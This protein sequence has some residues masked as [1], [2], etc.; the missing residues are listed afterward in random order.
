MT[1]TMTNPCREIVIPAVCNLDPLETLRW[2]KYPVG[3]NG[4]V[5]LVDWMG[6][7]DA[8]VQA[9]RTSYGKGT[10]KVSDDRNLIRYLYRHSHTTPFEMVEF[11]FLVQVPMDLWRQW[12][13]S[14]DI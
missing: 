11:K 9:A 5:C 13:R 12:I 6:N 7:D 14:I 2:T 10:K 4:F 8:I 3:S 1:K